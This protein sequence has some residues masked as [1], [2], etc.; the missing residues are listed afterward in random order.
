MSDKNNKLI[1]PISIIV[2]LLFVADLLFKGAVYR[3]LPTDLQENID[4]YL[5]K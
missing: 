1:F 2:I 3:Q 4:K 5:G